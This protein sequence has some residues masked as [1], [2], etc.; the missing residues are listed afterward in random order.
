ME[1]RAEARASADVRRMSHARQRF[2][3]RGEHPSHVCVHMPLHSP[4]RPGRAGQLCSQAP[5][6][7]QG[8]GPCT[9]IPLRLRPE[10]PAS[11]ESAQSPL[12]SPWLLLLLTGRCGHGARGPRASAR[13]LACSCSATGSSSSRT[14]RAAAPPHCARGGSRTATHRPSPGSG[15]PGIRA[16]AREEGRECCLGPGEQPGYTGGAPRPLPP[17]LTGLPR[18]RG[19]LCRLVPRKR[20]PQQCRPR[21][22]QLGRF[23]GQGSLGSACRELPARGAVPGG[24]GSAWSPSAP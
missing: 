17:P 14:T 4:S 12:P 23:Q 2:S 21:A 20:G 24:A 13:P 5:S 6:E 15:V 9:A 18:A 1:Q 19:P 10:N 7:G 11:A 8:V 22:W 3:S 16:G